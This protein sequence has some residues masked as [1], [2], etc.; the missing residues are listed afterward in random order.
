MAS[1]ILDLLRLLD[2][3]ATKKKVKVILFFDE[4]QQVGKIAKSMAIEGA[5]RNVAQETEH[6]VFIFSCSDCTLLASMFE[7]SNRPLYKLCDRINLN[8]IRPTDYKKFLNKV[9]KKAWNTSLGVEVLNEIFALTE[10]HP[11]YMNILCAKLWQNTE[12]PTIAY[13][14]TCWQQYVYDEKGTTAAELQTL[15][16]AQRTILKVIA[17]GKIVGLTSKDFLSEM[18]LPGSTVIKALSILGQKGYI[19]KT[20]FGQY[21]IIDPLIKWSLIM[22]A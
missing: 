5:I 18:H 12:P 3:L 1:N 11:Y 21:A 2:K 8:R 14:K 19:N 6:L 13:I 17:K 20:D 4:F 16:S 7:D 9:A 15:S 10:R 22:F